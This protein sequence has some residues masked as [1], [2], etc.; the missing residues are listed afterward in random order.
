MLFDFGPPLPGHANGMVLRATDA[1][2]DRILHYGIDLSTLGPLLQGAGTLTGTGADDRLI[3]SAGVDMLFG[4]AGDDFLHDGA[5]S[6]QMTG[7]AGADTFV[8]ARDG[9]AD[10]IQDFQQGLDHIDLSD[11]GRIY[12]AAS[13]TITSTATGAVISYGDERLEL[14]SSAGLALTLTD[15]DFLF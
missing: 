5:G 6:D 3:G 15:A 9:Q 8:L 14:T 4:G 7:G 10:H 1:Q 2:G 13:L 12:S 11:W